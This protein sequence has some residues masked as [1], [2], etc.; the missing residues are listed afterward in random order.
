MPSR[1][2]A[3]SAAAQGPSV[4]PCAWRDALLPELQKGLKTL[5]VHAAAAYVDDPGAQKALFGKAAAV[6][7]PKRRRAKKGAAEAA[8]AKPA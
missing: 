1:K 8:P 6:Q 4:G 7:A 2:S 3:A 5:R